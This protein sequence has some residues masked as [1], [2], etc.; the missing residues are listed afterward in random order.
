M[1]AH[2]ELPDIQGYEDRGVLELEM[3][4]EKPAQLVI[5][6]NI[7]GIHIDCMID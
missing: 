5:S 1:V 4:G 7:V 3:A 6:L 2:A